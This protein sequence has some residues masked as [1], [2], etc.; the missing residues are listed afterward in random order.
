MI[1]KIT[2][3]VSHAQAQLP[4]LV[5]EVCE[6]SATYGIRVHDEVKAYLVGRE[7]IEAIMETL[8][9]LANP[10]AME[11]IRSYE[12]DQSDM[13]PIDSFEE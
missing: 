5:K 10:K 9:T 12:A 2:Y 4:R 8:E 3:S 11:A 7:R 6:E 1:V 13:Q